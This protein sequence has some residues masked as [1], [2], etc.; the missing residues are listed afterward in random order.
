MV[1]CPHYR[2][3]EGI[4]DFLFLSECGSTGCRGELL[5]PLPKMAKQ[6]QKSKQTSKRLYD[7]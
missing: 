6:P 1:S 2:G 4:I 3:L 7:S 5:P